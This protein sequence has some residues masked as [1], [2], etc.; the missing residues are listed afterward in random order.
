[1]RLS[2]EQIDIIRQAARAAFGSDARVWLFGSRVDDGKR[3]SDIDLYIETPQPYARAIDHE[4]RFWGILQRRLGEQRIDII[5]R[6][7]DT[8][9]QAI[10]QVARTTG[11]PLL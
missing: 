8:S 1:M 10:H 7:A 3:G 5:T 2:P 9:P 4:T 11:V 6:A